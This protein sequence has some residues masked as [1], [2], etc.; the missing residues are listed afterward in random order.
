M[1]VETV[2]KQRTKVV[3]T[4][5][6]L[7]SRTVL[8]AVLEIINSTNEVH[9]IV[10]SLEFTIRDDITDV[11][12][13]HWPNKAIV[14]NI[15]E[16]L[17]QIIDD[18]RRGQVMRLTL[19]ADWM[20]NILLAAGHECGH[21]DARARIGE[22]YRQI[23]KE[24]REK[25][26]DDYAN[27]M[28]LYLAMNFNIEPARLADEPYLC[29]RLM[30]LAV[31]GFECTRRDQDLMKRGVI[32]ECDGNTFLT[33]REWIHKSFAAGEEWKQSTYPVRVEFNPNE[34]GE[35]KVFTT[36]LPTPGEGDEIMA[37]VVGLAM[38]ADVPDGHEGTYAEDERETREQ[39]AFQTP[40]QVA[41]AV[42]PLAAG[43]PQ[44]VPA[45][46]LKLPAHFQQVNLAGAAGAAAVV[47]AGAKKAYPPRMYPPNNYP[48]E[49]LIAFMT[50]VYQRLHFHAFNNCGW[51][52]TAVA[53]ATDW[54]Y[55]DPTAVIAKPC[56]ISDIIH[57]H[58]MP[59]VIMSYNTHD[60]QGR[61]MYGPW[62][63]KCNN[64]IVRGEIFK[65]AQTPG[66]TLYCNFYG[67]E[68]VRVVAPQ[69]LNKTSKY[70]LMARGGMCISWVFKKDDTNNAA[71]ADKK[72]D[73]LL[74]HFE[75]EKWIP[76]IAK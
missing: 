15:R 40:V 12:Q 57:R 69:N 76:A 75:N 36:T 62:S 59:D 19:Q 51:N 55:T 39:E 13:Y 22:K 52:G 56:D 41:T 1:Q 20:M 73:N 16:V 4:G 26:A 30:E 63:E 43:A 35:V 29:G 8:G 60:A 49:K 2:A 18:C 9:D 46:G 24:D 14:I 61:K 58:G 21:G 71:A 68:Y 34:K 42:V 11:A 7:V 10:K 31:K 64:G 53:G 25:S 3:I 70:A 38:G 33:L 48:A 47:A 44:I 5:A 37:D 72:D 45:I 65:Q 28:I 6:E 66:Y 17:D 54:T 50:E 27:V 67:N 74:G 23:S 32:Y